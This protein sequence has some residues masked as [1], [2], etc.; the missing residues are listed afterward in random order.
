M[1]FWAKQWVGGTVTLGSV[2]AEAFVYTDLN[3]VF[4]VQLSGAYVAA[5]VQQFSDV[6]AG[7]GN[8]A[9]TEFLALKSERRGQPTAQ[10]QV[11]GLATA[12]DGIYLA[13]ASS[14]DPTSRSGHI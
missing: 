13:D 3:I 14:V 6:V 4:S 2:P 7:A 1:L 10:F 8:A 5:D 9:N 12:P 11:L